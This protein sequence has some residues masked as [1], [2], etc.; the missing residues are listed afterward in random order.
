MN[1]HPPAS[2]LS[3]FSALALA[4]V[5]SRGLAFL[6]TLLIV[7]AFA[8]EAFGRLGV[9][10]TVVAYALQASAC[11]LDVYAVRHGARHPDQIGATASTVMVVRSALGLAAY[12]LLLAVCWAL[13]TLRPLLPLVA[14][15]GLTIF[16]G[17][18]S[19]AW[20]P[21]ALQQTRAMATALLA[22]GALYFAGVLIITTSGSPLWS[23][24]VAQVAA[25]AIVAVG[26]Y[27]WLQGRPERLVAPWPVAAWM[28]I[29]RESTPIGA[30]WLLRTVALGSDLVLLRLL[31]VGDAQIGWYNGA[32]RLFALMMGLSAVYFTILYPR[33]SQRAAE[34][35]GA[36]RIEALGSL[37]RVVPLALLGALGVA[38]LAPWTLALLFSPSFAGAA[39]ALRV[40]GAAA[41]VNV[42]NNH[43]RYMLLATG[44]QQVDL[45]NTA[46]AT[47]VHL[48]LKLA[49]IP[50]AGIEGAALGTLGGELAVLALGVWATRED[51]R[52]GD[53]PA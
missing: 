20:V 15:F 49:L 38:L 16:T 37:R 3:R 53:P 14:L 46:V 11:G 5:T 47:V 7:R 33:L 32:S 50:V 22:S 8:D 36:F 13:P 21:Q 42:I 18:L 30:S 29:L 17:A 39:M 25:E 34:S 31:L 6:G 28:G 2:T 1:G 41:M 35:P 24:P 26:L 51:F 44:R 45:R 48:A 23:V 27:R 4:D 10:T 43:F 52:R 40:L 12:T 19:L 9:A